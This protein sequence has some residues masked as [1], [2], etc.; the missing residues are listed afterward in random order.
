MNRAVFIAF[1]LLVVPELVLAQPVAQNSV[2]R[3]TRLT[4]NSGA[5]SGNTPPLC[6]GPSGP[7]SLRIVPNVAEAVLAPSISSN[8]LHVLR[9]G[10]LTPRSPQSTITDCNGN[11]IP[12]ECDIESGFSEDCNR[13][14]IPDE[15]GPPVLPTPIADPFVAP[16]CRFLSVS[17][18]P[19]LGTQQA[20]RVTLTSLHHVE[21]P[22]TGAPSVPFTSFEYG[23]NCEEGP[24]G[25]VRWVGPP[26]LYR[27]SSANPTMFMGATLQCTPH[28]QDWSTVGLVHITGTEIVPSSVY[29]VQAFDISCQGNE[30]ICTAVSCATQIKTSRWGDV[31]TPYNPPSPT[32]QPDVG[33]IAALVNK[34]RSAPGAP[35]KARAKLQPAVPDMST[36]VDFRDISSCVD[37]FRGLGYPFV[38]QSCP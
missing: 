20:I 14:G 38:I 22:Y 3:I 13:D 1:S 27:E 10:V 12:D 6:E 33:D 32:T 5:D 17:M 18:P 9:V 28:Y 31:E 21:P 19:V 23:A 34:F 30:G 29:D 15:C 35:I 2:H 25:C 36:D 26:A 11:G 24:T 16:K 37:A 8:S 4:V 7:V